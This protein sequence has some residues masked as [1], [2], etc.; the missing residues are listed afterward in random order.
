VL[1][2][3]EWIAIRELR[4]QGLSVSE[5]ARRHGY[6]RKT[7]GKVLQELAPQKHGNAERSRVSKLDPFKEYLQERVA[8]GCLNGAVL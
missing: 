6:D 4:R 2:V 1:R 8:Q 3:E 7:V 5:I